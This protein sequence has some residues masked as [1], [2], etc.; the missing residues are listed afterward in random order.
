MHPAYTLIFQTRELRLG[1][2][3]RQLTLTTGNSSDCSDLRELP[4]RFPP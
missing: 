4:A 1:F 3:G 2:L